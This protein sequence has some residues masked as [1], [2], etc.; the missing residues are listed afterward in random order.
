MGKET[1]DLNTAE[2]RARIDALIAQGV[3]RMDDGSTVV[4]FRKER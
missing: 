2:G 4:S 1:I 3:L